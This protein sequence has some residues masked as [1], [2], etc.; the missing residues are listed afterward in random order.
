MIPLLLR[1]TQVTGTRICL[2]DNDTL[3]EENGMQLCS[4]KQPLLQT[5]SGERSTQTDEPEISLSR[6]PVCSAGRMYGARSPPA[7]RPPSK[8]G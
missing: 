1:N 8:A 7:L 5:Q 6:A 2:C 4:T 3:G